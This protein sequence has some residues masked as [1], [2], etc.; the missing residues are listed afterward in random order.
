MITG[1]SASAA[2]RSAL[3]G[4]RMLVVLVGAR[5]QAR[6]RPLIPAEARC[7]L[8]VAFGPEPHAQAEPEQA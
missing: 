7:A 2:F 8:L 1:A 5:S 6:I 3:A 4:H